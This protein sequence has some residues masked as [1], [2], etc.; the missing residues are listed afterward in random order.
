VSKGQVS[1]AGY[2]VPEPSRKARD[3]AQP[4]LRPS[5]SNHPTVR[6]SASAAGGVEP[7]PRRENCLEGMAGVTVTFGYFRPLTLSP[8]LFKVNLRESGWGHPLAAVVMS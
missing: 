7:I 8:E 2:C 5:G 3:V 4:L 6:N 1:R